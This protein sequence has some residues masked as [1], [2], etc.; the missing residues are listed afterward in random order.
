MCATIGPEYFPGRT[1]VTRMVEEVADGGGVDKR[2]TVEKRG[3]VYAIG[4]VGASTNV[5]GFFIN[6]LSGR[7]GFGLE[8]IA[9]P[10][11]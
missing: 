6:G 10:A 2:G 3:T 8:L 4:I 7:R 11:K 5:F 1:R 9:I